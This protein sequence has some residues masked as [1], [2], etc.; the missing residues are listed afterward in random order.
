MSMI[1]WLEWNKAAFEKAKQEDK[2]IILDIFG[3][4]CYWCMR[5][6]KDT[7]ENP[8]IAEI[9][10]E[11]FVPVR[12]DTDKR[13]DINERYNQGGWPTTCFLAP[14]GEIIVGATYVPP[15]EMKKL[16]QQV[17]KFYKEKKEEIERIKPKKSKGAAL[18]K[19]RTFHAID[20]SI[21]DNIVDYLYENF[22]TIYG[23]F[24]FAP[25]FPMPA[26]R[27]PAAGVA[28]AISGCTNSLEPTM[29]PF[30]NQR[31]WRPTTRLSG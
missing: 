12:V 1:K 4:W 7:Y 9:I 29:N 26:P 25:K 14:E 5:I 6:E 15:H 8:E 31:S 13:P 10:N 21:I 30:P 11:N 22:D 17:L 24:Y 28:V 3:T 16:L 2:P 23:G 27:L 18:I 20:K 19:E